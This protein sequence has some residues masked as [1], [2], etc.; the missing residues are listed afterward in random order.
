MLKSNWAI[1]SRNVGIEPVVT[2]NNKEVLVLWVEAYLV[3]D[4][5]TYL[6]K[7]DIEFKVNTVKVDY[8]KHLESMLEI[9]NWDFNTSDNNRKLDTSIGNLLWLCGRQDKSR[10]KSLLNKYR[11]GERKF[12]WE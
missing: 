4:I 9:F 8:F 3:E 5:T 11:K 6:Q 10:T 2:I 1:K 7:K 12:L